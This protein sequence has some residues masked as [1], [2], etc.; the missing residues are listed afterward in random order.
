MTCEKVHI[1]WIFFN[2]YWVLEM[3]ALCHEISEMSCSSGKVDK[4][5]INPFHWI[6]IAF[7]HVF[8]L[9]CFS[10]CVFLFWCIFSVALYS[11]IM[12]VMESVFELS[13]RISVSVLHEKYV[14][15]HVSPQILVYVISQRRYQIQTTNLVCL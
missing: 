15:D 9:D 12:K 3:I 1:Y 8:S 7:S 6:L 4:I 14:F 2:S 5:F 10:V 13:G 11:N